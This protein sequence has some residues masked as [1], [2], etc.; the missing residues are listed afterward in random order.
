[1]RDAFRF[2]QEVAELVQVLRAH[3]RVLI[4]APAVADGDSVGSQLALEYMFRRAFPEL[5]IFIVNDE[6]PAERYRAVSG[7]ERLL[8]PETMA[9]R[10][11]PLE[12]D[13]GIAV[14][15]GIDR[16]GRLY[17]VFGRCRHRIFIDHHA[18]SCRYP[19]TLSI[20]QPGATSATEI[21]H[22][23]SQLAPFHTP[24][25]PRFAEWL[26][27]G[28]VCDTG[29]FRNPNTTPE[30]L[31]LA[32]T[33][34]RSGFDAIRHGHDV[35]NERSVAGLRL[36]ADSVSHAQFELDGRVVWATVTQEDL[37]RFHGCPDDREGIVDALMST[38]GV[39]VA[40]L[41]FELPGGGTKVSL[42]SRGAVDVARLAESF[43]NGGG[44]RKAAGLEVSLRPSDVA[45]LL[46]KKIDQALSAKADARPD[47]PRRRE[48]EAVPCGL[49]F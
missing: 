14:D 28:L 43:G 46:V 26:Y 16:A 13:V 31:E 41:L 33:L 8:T 49:T 17:P 11:E 27:L 15:G 30:V 39:E 34:R 38:R 44:H 2:R 48:G 4:T 45:G 32:A 29:V 10:G 18:V 40:A 47:V 42:R 5:E 7:I 23:I 36:L 3:R 24:L 6:P 12:F 9:E 1:M 21:I 19:Y 37:A 25:V 22:A 35:M 20:V